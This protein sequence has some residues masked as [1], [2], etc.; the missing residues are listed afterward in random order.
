MIMV[1]VLFFQALALRRGR[2][3]R[4]GEVDADPPQDVAKR[5]GLA[6][7]IG[8]SV[9][10]VSGNYYFLQPLSAYVNTHPVY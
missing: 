9:Y 2:A 7:L 4:R 6:R 5:I 1:K 10:V 3:G 8:L